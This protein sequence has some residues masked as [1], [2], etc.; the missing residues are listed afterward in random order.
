[1]IGEL[2]VVGDVDGYL[3]WLDRRDG[4]IVARLEVGDGPIST[5]PLAEGGRI[6]VLGDDGTLAALSPGS[7]PPRRPLPPPAPDAPSEAAAEPP[8]R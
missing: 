4:R 8:G 2:L 7:A 1:M 3:H 5:R 6:Y